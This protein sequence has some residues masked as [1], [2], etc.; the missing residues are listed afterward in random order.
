[1]A[2]TAKELAFALFNEGKRPKDPE[3]KALGLKRRST[4]SYF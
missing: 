1:M 2:E 3:V 4:Y